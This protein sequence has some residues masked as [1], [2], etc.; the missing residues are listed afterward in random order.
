MS[1]LIVNSLLILNGDLNLSGDLIVNPTGTVIPIPDPDLKKTFYNYHTNS[2]TTSN[3]QGRTITTLTGSVVILGKIDGKGQGYESDRGPGANSTQTDSYDN[4]LIGYGA[5]HAGLGYISDPNAPAPF[6]PYGNHETPVSLGSGSTLYHPISE[7]F[8]TETKGGGAIKIVA[9]SGSI[10]VDGEIIMDGDDGANVGG[11]SGGSVWLFGWNIAG[12]GNISA[13][14]G[15]TALLS[16]AGGGGGGYISLWHDK[17][18][19]FTG[20]M[21]VIGKTGAGDGNIFAKQTE[22]ILEERFTGSIWNTKWWGT[23]VNSVTLDNDVLLTLPD[24]NTSFP[25]VTS[26]FNVSGKNITAAVDYFTT[27]SEI[28]QYSLNFFM[29]AD[30]QNWF[31]LSRRPTGLFGVSSSD[32]STSA[33]GIPFSYSNV[34]FRVMKLDST[35][36]FQ[37]YDATST[38][39]TIY[40]DVRTDLASKTYNVFLGVDK[41]IAPDRVRQARLTPLDISNQ[42]VQMDGSFSDASSVALNVFG[43]PPQ[44]Y[45]TDFT[46]AGNRVMWDSTLGSILETGDVVRVIYESPVPTGQIEATFDSM[47]IYDGVV[48][49]AESKEPVL[50][51]DPDFGSDSSEGRQLTPL[52]NLFVASA[53]SKKGGTVVL[54]DGTHNPTAVIRKDLTIRGAEGVKPLITSQYVQDTTGSD[55]ENNALSFYGCQGRVEN[56]QI[57]DSSVGIRIENTTQFEVVRNLIYDVTTGV[58]VIN[59]DPLIMRNRIYDTSVAIDLTNSWDP[60]VY[61]NVLHDSSVGVHAG[62]VLDFTVIG[63]TIDACDTCLLSDVSSTGIMTSNNFTNSSFGVIADMPMA[64]HCNCYFNTASP[65]LGP[66]TTDFSDLIYENPGYVNSYAAPALKDYHLTNA[67]ADQYA[68]SKVDDN[69]MVDMD[70]ANRLDGTPSIGAYEYIPV[71]PHTGDF[72]VAGNGD[73]HRNFGGINDPFRTLDKAMLVADATVRIDGGHYDSYYL[74]LRSQNIVFDSPFAIYVEPLQ[75]FIVYQTVTATNVANG[76]ISLPGIVTPDDYSNVALNVVGGF[77]QNYGTDFVIESEDWFSNTHLRWKGLGLD[78]F[79]G[80]GD[81]F[82]ILFTGGLQHKFMNFVIH[83][84]YSNIEKERAIFVSPNG[85]DS[86]AMGGDGT[87]TGGNGTYARPYRTINMALSTS[88]A[89]DYI[90]AIAGE[91][92]IFNGMEDRVVVPA[93]DRTSVAEK[94]PRK[95]Y[96]DFFAP[97]DFRAY[98]TTEYDVVPWTLDYAGDSYATVGGGFLSFA[99]D[100][101]NRVLAQTGFQFR[102]DF[103]AQATLRN[104]IDPLNF[105]VSNGDSSVYFVCSGSDYTAGVYTGGTNY[106]V[107]GTLALDTFIPDRIVT[108]YVSVN[109]N[110]IT[111]KYVSLSYLPNP[112]SS[113]TTLSVVGGVSQNYGVDYYIDDSKIKW[114]GMTLDGDLQPGDIL[115]L[116]YVDIRLSSAIRVSL[117]LTGSVFTVKIFENR[118]RTIFMKDIASSYLGPWTASFLMNQRLD[119]GMGKGFISQFMVIGSLFE[120]STVDQTLTSRTER[121]HLTIY[122]NS[123]RADFHYRL[124]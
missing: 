107:D 52:K 44:Y 124:T 49:N 56:V 15:T 123:L 64:S 79:V 111:N 32:G 118:W 34:T 35:F 106:W 22:P 92:P 10:V 23:P 62:V 53:W 94:V 7:F 86:T 38:P 46:T 120:N 93:I 95:Y 97:V 55:W 72:Y 3:G 122:D 113:N 11:A 76:W 29:K 100:G 2:Y 90:V 121:K 61:S 41:P 77:P 73:D 24:G 50:Y 105:I 119:D 65:M 33:S 14:G 112:D 110:D 91:Y 67:S 54:Y 71:T 102:N 16:N 31:G 75:H 40:T 43:G 96:E 109:A 103:E 13:E 99:Y 28:D 116:N 69:Y 83:G 78:G 17:A 6:K 87:N 84:H 117:S 12:T 74:N 58:Q 104:A 82:R 85:S 57:T 36:L 20:S 47:R 26:L 101:T 60:Y 9:R 21:S 45:G 39:Q 1:S 27:G 66:I 108:D 5:T 59:C 80:A 51:V 81:V 115:R 18:N 30:E 63:N 88:T 25:S 37:F 89:G 19:T 68:G 98:G 4:F 70:G 42:Y 114:D 48:G 8:G